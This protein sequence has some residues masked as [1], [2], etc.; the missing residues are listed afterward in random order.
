M[1][2]RSTASMA[3]PV[4]LVASPDDTEYHRGRT[5]GGDEGGQLW[6][7]WLFSLSRW[8]SSCSSCGRRPP[9]LDGRR[10]VSALRARSGLR[11]LS[12]RR[13]RS[14]RTT[15]PSSSGNWSAAPSGTTAHPPD[16]GSQAGRSDAD[17]MASARSPGQPSPPPPGAGGAGQPGPLSVSARAPPAWELPPGREASASATIGCAASPS[18]AVCFP[19]VA[20][21]S[22]HAGVAVQAGRDHVHERQVEDH[23]DQADDVPPGRAP[24]PPPG[25]RPGVQVSGVDDPGDE[26]PGLLRVPAPEPAPGRLRPDGTG[27]DREGPDR[28]TE[29]GG[30][31]RHPVECG[32]PGQPGDQ[33]ALRHTARHG[34]LVV[35]EPEQVQDAG[36]AA[37]EEDPEADDRGAHMDRQP[38]RA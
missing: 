18:A 23:H 19:T 8:R 21:P 25:G 37:D 38:L 3:H 13:G 2:C 28:E 12:T 31:V 1:S 15:T 20:G 32:G 16:L 5:L 17:L 35:A 14:P 7:S 22:V 34:P 9:P 6:C 11:A 29:D 24:A 10:G 30:T 26:G 4:P 27:D 36:D 33:T